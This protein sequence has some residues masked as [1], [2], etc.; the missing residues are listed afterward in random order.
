MDFGPHVNSKHVKQKSI[1]QEI[2]IQDIWDNIIP[3]HIEKL[4]TCI[5]ACLEK[6]IRLKGK[7]LGK[8]GES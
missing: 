7:S 1:K 6:V 4:A 2:L 8:K 3:Q 5:P